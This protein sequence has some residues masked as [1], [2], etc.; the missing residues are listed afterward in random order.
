MITGTLETIDGAENIV[1]TRNVP[2]PTEKVWDAFAVS[3]RL[4][5]W[6][7]TWTG[8]PESGEVE[9]SM[10]FEEEAGSEPYVIVVCDQPQHL[11]VHN[12]HED[13]AQ[14]WT[15]DVQFTRVDGGTHVKFAMPLPPGMEVKHVGAGWEYYLDRMVETVETGQVSTKEWPPYEA[16]MAEYQSELG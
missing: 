12:L 4:A 3:D 15:V 10:A 2:A 9:V 1:L 5:L 13:P 11:R 14:I 16:L 6:F 7:G 8:N